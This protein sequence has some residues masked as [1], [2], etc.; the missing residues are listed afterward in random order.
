VGY[1]LEYT[2]LMNGGQGKL[3]ANYQEL[4]GR[5]EESTAEEL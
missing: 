2:Y 3:S 1:R 5:S 4:S